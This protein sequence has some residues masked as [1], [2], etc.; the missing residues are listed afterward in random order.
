MTNASRKSNRSGSMSKS[1]SCA[2]GQS[3]TANAVTRP[4]QAA[5]TV[6]RCML[7]VSCQTAALST[8][9]PSSGSPGTRLS[10]PTSRFPKASPSTTMQQQPVGHDEP[11][12]QRRQADRQRGQRADHRDPELLARLLRLRLD[13][14][15]AAEEVQRDR[16]HREA[17]VPGG[18]ARARPRAGAPR[19]RARPRR[20]ARRRTSRP[21][22]PAGPP[23]TRGATTT[24]ISA[25]TTNQDDVTST[26]LPAIVP[27][28]NVPGGRGT[29]GLA[30]GPD[31]LPR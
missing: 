24:A 28:L 17:V 19:G 13:R 7:P 9:P 8:R 22:A 1:A 20:R 2:S 5:T 18:V 23:P 31:T 15:H 11:Q 16:G 12:P 4:P 3:S 29:W 10:A 21:R 14:G 25:A 26:S 30:C 6:P 27:I